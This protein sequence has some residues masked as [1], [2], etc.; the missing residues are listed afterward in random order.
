[1]KVINVKKLI[2]STLIFLFSSFYQPLLAD[3]PAAAITQ[4]VAFDVPNIV[5]LQQNSFVVRSPTASSL[6]LH[7]LYQMRALPNEPIFTQGPYTDLNAGFVWANQ[8]GQNSLEMA[9]SSI[10]STLQP[11]FY[12]KIIQASGYLST[13]FLL[14][15]WKIGQ[16]ELNLLILG[17]LLF[18]SYLCFT[19]Y[20][21]RGGGE[22]HTYPDN[23]LPLPSII[24]QTLAA[25]L[26]KIDKLVVHSTQAELMSSAKK[27]LELHRGKSVIQYLSELLR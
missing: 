17:Y 16:G 18:S 22:I 20:Q 13:L 7:E 23:D 26:A 9:L 27:F 6:L 1:M 8:K 25:N 12:P 19:G 14:P 2:V 24:V 5:T 11:Q 3:T 10:M 15:P 21:K 4:A